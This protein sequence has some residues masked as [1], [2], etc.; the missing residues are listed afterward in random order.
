LS[1]LLL[2]RLSTHSQFQRHNGDGVSSS[3]V[4]PTDLSVPFIRGRISKRCGLSILLI[5]LV[6]IIV[7][8]EMAQGSPSQSIQP[9]TDIKRM[10]LRLVGLRPAG[11]GQTRRSAVLFGKEFSS[12][13][14]GDG[15]SDDEYDGV[16]INTDDDLT[17]RLA[18]FNSVS[19]E[20]EEEEEEEEEATSS[21]H[22]PSVGIMDNDDEK[23]QATLAWFNAAGSDDEKEDSEIGS[24]DQLQSS[25][26]SHGPSVGIIDDDDEKL[27]ATLA[28]FNSA[29]S[30]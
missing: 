1:L 2:Y 30:E 19:F 4:N 22:R 27:Q 9:H 5:C 7:A 13:K 21:S 10:E 18:F 20:K 15:Q 28:L 14:T 29:G 24:T 16:D 23:L 25:S 11:F 12:D 8:L 6:A 26:F 17:T 3:A